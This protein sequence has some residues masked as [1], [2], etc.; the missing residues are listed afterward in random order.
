MKRLFKYDL[1]LIFITFILLGIGIIQVFS[2]SYYL[3]V[4]KPYN[5]LLINHIKSIGIGVTAML[6]FSLFPYKAFKKI[7]YLAIIPLVF[8]FALLYTDA[9]FIVN[10]SRRWIKIAGFS[11]MPSEWAKIFIII[12]LSKALYMREKFIKDFFMG[13]IPY[14]IF[15]LIFAFLVYQQPNM[16]DAVI[17]MSIVIGMIFISGIKIKHL[18][19]IIITGASG[20]TYM[21]T[22]SNYRMQR[23]LTF[24]DPFA[25]PLNFGYQSIQSLYALGS[26]G[27]FGVGIGLSTQN[28]LYL[29]ESENDFILATIAEEWGFIG[30][31]ITLFL[32]LILIYKGFR[33]AMECEDKFGLYLASGITL[34]L[35]LHVIINF[36]V[37]GSLMPVTGITLPL[38][39]YGGN[40]I[41]VVLISIGILLNISRS[42]NILKEEK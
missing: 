6:V 31:V 41:L 10:G 26:G 36:L 21:I 14:L 3:D 33:I 2:S 39:S 7:G 17:I 13:V 42:N 23:F 28:K 12:I 37:V 25:D 22:S 38:I 29:P 5:S 11:F 18:L 35:S 16:S 1:L 24:R 34:M 19:F 27:L 32:F 30:V 20:L 9:A 4:N 15:G 8:T 40:A